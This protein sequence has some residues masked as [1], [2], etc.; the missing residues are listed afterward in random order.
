M[1][2]FNRGLIGLVATLIMIGL[3]P[4][5]AQAMPSTAP[6]AA[7]PACAS[8][9]GC[10]RYA[11]MQ[12]FYDRVIGMIRE[13]ST[14]SYNN[15]PQPNAYYYIVSGDSMAGGPDC[16]VA[17]ASAYFLCPTNDSIYVGQDQLWEFY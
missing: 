6:A 15:M 8:L 1:R 12:A 13:F 2:R 7:P 17:T 3:S 16:S 9:E 5:A 14:A 11:D 10:Y 4:S